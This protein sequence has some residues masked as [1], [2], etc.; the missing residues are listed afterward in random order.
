[1]LRPG[2]SRP[3]RGARIV[4]GG[5]DRL[6]GSLNQGALPGDTRDQGIRDGPALYQTVFAMLILTRLL[7][8][9]GSSR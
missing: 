6:V 8:L 3:Q 5:L 2:G 1:M 7:E 9:C 4:R